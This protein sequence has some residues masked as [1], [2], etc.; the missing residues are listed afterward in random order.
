MSRGSEAALLLGVHY[1]DLVH[2]VVAGVPSALVFGNYPDTGQPAWTLQGKALAFVP[3]LDFGT[4]N[5]SK[6]PDA[7]IPVDKIKGPMFTAYGGADTVWPSCA[8]A[9]A[10]TKRL[11][12]SPSPYPHV[13]L[14]YPGAGHAV[15]AMS[16]YISLTINGGDGGTVAA[17]G[18][19]WPIHTPDNG[20]SQDHIA[21]PTTRHAGLPTFSP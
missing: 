11:Q 3:A 19:L 5:L 13:A 6:Y 12:A 2:G 1:P 14:N 17:K 4:T 21:K 15:G 20:I 10:I 9:S 18:P 7:V 8:Y 16:G